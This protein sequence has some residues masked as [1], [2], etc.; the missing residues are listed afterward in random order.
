MPGSGGMFFQIGL[1]V[2]PAILVVL[3][4]TL[5]GMRMLRSKG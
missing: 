2:M 1:G 5:V 3:I 4:G